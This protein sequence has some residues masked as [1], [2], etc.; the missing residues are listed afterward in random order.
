ML[1]LLSR[2]EMLTALAAAPIAFQVS[3][4][5]QSDRPR[6][7]AGLATTRG[8]RPARLRHGAA[9]R[10]E[11]LTADTPLLAAIRKC[12]ILVPEFHGQWSAVEWRRGNPWFG[13]YDLILA[14]AEAQ[15]QAVRGHSLI[16]EQMTPEWARREMLDERD[17]RTVERHF[18]SLLPRYEGRIEDWIVV[19]EMIDTEHGED[20]IRRTS[21]QRAYGSSYVLR[22]LE[23][24]R[25]FDSSASLM[26]NEY[27]LY[28]D[29]PIDEARRVALVQ[30]A[31]DLKKRGAPLDK[32]GLQGHLEL[33][34]GVIPQRRLERFFADLANTGVKLAVTELDVLEADRTRPIAERDT[35]VAD[36][37]Q[38]FLDVATEQPALDSIV[39]WGLSDRDSWL[40]ERDTT[41][42]VALGCSPVDCSSLN[43]GLPYDADM[44][45]KLML[46]SL[47]SHG[48]ARLA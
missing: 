1:S 23:T 18:A 14:F 10:P 36:A 25:Q 31:E 17:W 2:R 8:S 12:D 35:I 32:I 42:K 47:S 4:T 45:P 46:S 33:S 27:G 43:R 34:K 5:D 26:I 6:N 21:F 11:Q 30:L 40:Q 38:S 22:A 41:T 13:N 9:I 37:I 44:R 16:W 19:N 29:N 3:H 7:D 28:F 15:G 20:N 48:A 39:T 24:A